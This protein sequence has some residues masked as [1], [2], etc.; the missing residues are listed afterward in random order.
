MLLPKTCLLCA[1]NPDPA[2][3]TTAEPLQAVALAC[4]DCGSLLSP[5]C[6][7]VL[8]QPQPTY[9]RLAWVS[10]Q[11]PNMPWD[12]TELWV[13]DVAPDGSLTGQHK[14]RVRVTMQGGRALRGHAFAAHSGSIQSMC[15]LYLDPTQALLSSP[16]LLPDRPRWRAAQMSL[17]CC[18]SG[19]PT[20]RCSLCQ[21]GSC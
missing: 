9:R 12:D 18:R 5:P 19:A 1:A 15:N 3:R 16:L 2:S 8:L 21:V 13:A 17:W 14:V 7:A 20:A 10:W 4:C 11:H 6:Q